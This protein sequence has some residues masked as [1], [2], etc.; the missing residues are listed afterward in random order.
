M[1]GGRCDT[2]PDY[3]MSLILRGKIRLRVV[4]TP[5]ELTRFRLE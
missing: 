3:W 4:G 1:P 5:G 2:V